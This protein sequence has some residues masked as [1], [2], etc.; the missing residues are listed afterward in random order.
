MR[1]KGILDRE[2]ATDTRIKLGAPGALDVIVDGRTI[3]SHK[4]TGAMPNAE[5]ILARVRELCP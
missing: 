2:L 5:R 3:F 1:L 4:E